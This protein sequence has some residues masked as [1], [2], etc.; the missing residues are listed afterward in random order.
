MAA[1]ATALGCVNEVNGGDESSRPGSRAAQPSVC[2]P[3]GADTNGAVDPPRPLLVGSTLV[4]RAC[5]N[6]ADHFLLETADHVG[7]LLSVVIE[8]IGGRGELDI[9]VTAAENDVRFRSQSPRGERNISFVATAATYVLS[10][11]LLAD[12]AAESPGRLYTARLQRLSR[13]MGDCCAS[14][15]G[16]G[17]A[18]DAILTCLCQ[19]DNACCSGPYDATCVAEARGSCSLNCAPALPAND[20]C[21]PNGTGGC[22]APEVQACV[23]AIDP[24]CC[25]GG[26]DDHCVNLA[27]H[28]CGATCSIVSQ[29]SP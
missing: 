2:I 17:C 25:V 23:C 14:H 27:R 22:S 12:L 1:W 13:S 8:Q 19:V 24:F 9:S 10:V 11:N 21:T 15:E 4:G 7:A 6:R 20:C 16:A 26:F 5:A 28:R 18:D 3:E 29:E